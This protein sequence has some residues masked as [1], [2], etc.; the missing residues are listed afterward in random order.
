MP[1]VAAA[2]SVGGGADAGAINATP[3]AG[4]SPG[5]IT[6]PLTSSRIASSTVIGSSTT[7]LRGTT[8]T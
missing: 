1:G 4:S 2:G 8:R 7:L 6:P 5:P 3:F